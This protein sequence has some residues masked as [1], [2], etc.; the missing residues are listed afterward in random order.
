MGLFQNLFKKT[1]NADIFSYAFGLAAPDLRDFDYKAAYKGWVYACVTAIAEDVAQA[2]LH[3]QRLTKDG[4]V[5]QDDHISLQTLR[6]V[7]SFMTFSE[8]LINTQSF[9]ELEGNAFWYVPTGSVT[10]KPAEIWPLDPSRMIVIRDNNTF[11]GG[12]IYKN[13]KGEQIPFSIKEI[14]HFK[15]FNPLNRYRGMGTVAAAALA[16]D[17]DTY[18]STWNRNFFFNSAMPSATLET[19]KVM[20]QEQL[21]RVKA[22][23]DSR[24]KGTEN[25]HKLAIL[26]GGLKFNPVQVSQK[27]M[28]FLEQRKFSRDEIMAIFRVP[29]TAILI[30]EGVNRANAEAVDYVFSKRVIKPRIQFIVD[31]LNEFYLPLFN[32]DT[33]KARFDFKDPTPENTELAIKVYE[34]GVNKW[35]TIN[36]IREEEGKEPVDGGDQI[37]LPINVAPIGKVVNPQLTPQGA[38]DEKMVLKVKKST[39]P[40][41]K[42]LRF[43]ASEIVERKIQYQEVFLSQ[44]SFITR[45][46]RN[47]K[48][49]KAADATIQIAFDG[50]DDEYLPQVQSINID[51]LTAV[52]LYAGKEAM[53]QVK[54]DDTFNLQNPRVVNWLKE[55]ALADATSIIE[56]AK[57]EVRRRISDG[58]DNGLSVQEI[59]DMIASFFDTQSEWRALRI[60]RTEVI[61]GYAQGSIEAYKQSGVVEKKQWLTNGATDDLCLE[62]QAQGP[63]PLD[64]SFASGDDAPP[65]HPNCRCVLQPIVDESS[66]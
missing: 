51:T 43:I 12:Y 39:D 8:L 14:I 30:T 37:Y 54:P 19:D 44:K 10:K 6:G 26:M 22:E 9:L 7:N 52:A 62:N 24:Y 42:R 40:V 23:W 56:T 25:A 45:N 5:N 21:N 15:R 65:L 1:V 63:I 38:N 41:E 64:E 59:S 13:E 57:D 60:A 36:D 16:I 53:S 66:N 35:L 28:E 20:T 29:K 58:V 17:T 32:E 3:F 31:R 46:L 55:H 33:T 61:S 50:F 49:T 34:A 4:W 27:D 2:E 11:V 47:N 48:T 18:A